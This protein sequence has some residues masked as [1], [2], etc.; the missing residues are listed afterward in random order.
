MDRPA[1]GLA[2]CS[3]RERT[4]VFQ[5]TDF[6]MIVDEPHL[7]CSRDTESAA[8]SVEK[9]K[10]VRVRTLLLLLWGALATGFIELAIFVARKNLAV[11]THVIYGMSR[12]FP[13]MIP[14]S[15]LLIFA[16]FGL[17]LALVMRW[18]R[19]LGILM[20]D[21][22]LVFLFSLTL[23]LTIRGLNA[24]SSL[25]LAGGVAAR[26][27]P[28]LKKE[29]LASRLQ[30]AIRW[31][32][33]WL[34]GAWIALVVVCVGRDQW[35][36][37]QTLHALP[38]PRVGAPN[39]LLIVMDT[40]R[41]DHLSAYGYERKTSPQLS[42]LAARGVRF[43][44]ATATAPWT[45]PSHSSMFTG[46]WP[47]ELATLW[48]KPLEAGVPTLA[49]FFASQ[50]YATAGFVA[51]HFNCS[52]ETGLDRGFAHYEDYDVSP[53]SVLGSSGLGWLCVKAAAMLRAE[54][55]RVAGLEPSLLLSRGFRRKDAPRINRDVLSWLDANTKRPFFAF[56]N[57]FDAHDP[58]LLPEG[59]GH[60]FGQ[61]PKDRAD[62]EL[63]RDWLQADKQKLNERQ[64]TL[65]RDSYDDCIAYLD[66]H[67]GRL[68]EELER[69]ELLETT[70]VAVT[71]DH[72]EHFGEH[73]FFGHGVSLYQGEVHVPLIIVDPRFMTSGTVASAPVSLRDL[74][75]TFADLAGLGAR[76]NLPGA[77]LARFWRSPEG[78]DC[79]GAEPVLSE[80]E[81]SGLLK[82]THGPG[83]QMG[84]KSVTT[85]DGV[86]LRLRDGN[87]QYYDLI[88]DPREL[89]NLVQCAT[90]QPQLDRSRDLLEE[91]TRN[92]KKAPP[93]RSPKSNESQD[94]R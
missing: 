52:R 2:L 3:R 7:I 46:R 66:H 37:R 76:F 59:V 80:V 48:G 61:R 45:L 75:A 8:T 84:A 58:Y 87:E 19:R 15:S 56:V 28:W 43:E 29:R 5:T 68:F 62:T 92:A 55:R 85:C 10:R 67:L 42:R 88:R 13:W 26:G 33:P 63:L 11:G 72:G 47:H 20:R 49:E 73:G 12:H 71:S 54:F 77:S 4:A 25:L 91:M 30:A 41:A 83:T 70:I 65:A 69:R 78:P 82:A 38:K 39:V 57:Y 17:L 50:G 53:A 9:E 60:H 34:A 23:L 93:G 90:I 31:S 24:P 18:H 94:Q 14:A 1:R 27:V 89:E 32:L 81:E 21:Y 64:V 74:P 16:V 86:Y 35:G 79:H 44:Q 40:V 6:S 36:E 22:G 51:N